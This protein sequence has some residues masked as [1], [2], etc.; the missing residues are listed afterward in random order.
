MS[1]SRLHYIFLSVLRSHY[2]RC[3]H[4]SVRVRQP[5]RSP[6]PDTNS[7]R[8]EPKAMPL[9]KMARPTAAVV[10]VAAGVTVT[11]PLALA[12][13]A[14][15]LAATTRTTYVL[16]AFIHV[17]C[18]D[19]CVYAHACV[20]GFIVARFLPSL[21]RHTCHILPGSV[22]AIATTYHHYRCYSALLSD[23]CRTCQRCRWAA[24]RLRDCFFSSSIK[25]QDGEDGRRRGEQT[26]GPNRF[27][28]TV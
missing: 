13:A 24:A 22:S 28:R 10:V 5:S 16:D 4:C 3:R 26:G 18:P 17:F 11:S 2:C 25:R 19:A 1:P 12:S 21:R 15:V 7:G 14:V 23:C 8:V 9:L 20:C 27:L 6:L